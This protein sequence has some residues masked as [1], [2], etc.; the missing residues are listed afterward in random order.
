MA[1]KKRAKE[2]KAFGARNSLCSV[3][4]FQAGS[5]ASTRHP[6]PTLA[7][8][9]VIPNTVRMVLTY[10]AEAETDRTAGVYHETS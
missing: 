8:Q 10:P 5:L 6:R 3:R 4:L 2:L 9:V 7:A 1:V